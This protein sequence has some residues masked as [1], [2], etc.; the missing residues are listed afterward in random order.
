[1]DNTQ[2]FLGGAA[3]AGFVLLVTQAGW[4][5]KAFLGFLCVASV[6]LGVLAVTWPRVR[7]GAPKLAAPID[8]AAATGALWFGILVLCLLV[9]GHAQWKARRAVKNVAPV[10][11]LPPAPVEAPLPHVRDSRPPPD[12]DLADLVKRIITL[13]ERPDSKDVHAQRE[14]IRRLGLEIADKVR[15]NCLTVLGA[16]CGFPSPND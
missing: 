9:A 11:A 13:K 8:S 12:F 3:I 14:F 1:M 16:V 6:V 10:P 15:I 4:K 2:T 5:H 7:A